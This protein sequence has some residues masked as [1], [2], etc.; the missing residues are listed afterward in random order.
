MLVGVD[1]GG[2]VVLCFGG[3]RELLT[4]KRRDSFPRYRRMG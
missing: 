2:V 1:Y 3:A 4:W